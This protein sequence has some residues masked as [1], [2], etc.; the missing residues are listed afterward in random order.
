MEHVPVHGFDSPGAHCPIQC[1]VCRFE[2]K[3]R[4]PA[5]FSRET[6]AVGGKIRS[7]LTARFI[8]FLLEGQLHV[9]LGKRNIYIHSGQG[10]FFSGD[11][12]LE[13]TAMAASRIVM[14]DFN[15]HA[16]LARRAIYVKSIV[17]HENR[18]PKLPILDLNPSL[19]NTL[20]NM[21][22]VESPCWHLMKEY[23][24]F[25][26]LVT[27]YPPKDIYWLLRPTLRADIDFEAFVINNYQNNCSLEEIAAMANLSL[28]YFMRRFKAVFGM[29]AHQWLVKQK[30]AELLR[31]LANGDVNTKEISQKLGFKS[32]RGL[33]Q[34]CRTQFG[35]TITSLIDQIARQDG[36]LLLEDSF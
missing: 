20:E 4:Y 21:H 30:K 10:M 3:R 29:P 15:N 13:I 26:T 19:M 17:Y 24:L 12:A 36:H 27:E 25:F 31:C 35:C 8:L 18:T 9:R 5:R 11:Q 16:I 23:D 14:L 34:F 6:L 33:Y 7:E 28:S 2:G 1:P 22:I 32:Q